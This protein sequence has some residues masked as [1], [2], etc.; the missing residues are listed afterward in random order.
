[1]VEEVNAAT[2]G[3]SRRNLLRSVGLVTTAVGLVAVG[4][5]PAIGAPRTRKHL[6]GATASDVSVMQ[7]ALALEHEGIAAYKIAGGSGLLSQG[8]LDVALVFLGHH[9]GHRD[10]LAKLIAQAGAKPVESKS[11]D[12]YIKEL[13]IAALKSQAD[14]IKFAAGLEQG[15]THAY[16]GQLS[17]LQDKQTAHLFGQLGADEAVHWALLN[18]AAGGTVPKPAFLFS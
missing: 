2:E 14:V 6:G 12:D 15:A 7:G 11:N 13:N 16:V 4:A 8:V 17:A 10:A 9:E 3:T 5:A 1:M 18:S